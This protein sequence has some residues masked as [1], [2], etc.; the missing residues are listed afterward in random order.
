[1]SISLHKILSLLPSQ[2]K[3][4][5][6]GECLD[7]NISLYKQRGLQTQFLD[8]KEFLYFADNSISVEV[9]S[10]QMT[11]QENSL[12]NLD[13]LIQKIF[14]SGL[15]GGLLMGKVQGSP[16]YCKE[17]FLS[18]ESYSK[19]REGRLNYFY[20]ESEDNLSFFLARFPSK[21]KK[22]I[23]LSIN[24]ALIWGELI[25]E[26]LEDKR[27]ESELLLE[28]TLKTD[29]TSLFCHRE[30]LLSKDE[31]SK[32]L[33]ALKKREE[34][35]PLSYITEHRGFMGLDFF[36]S[37]SVLI[38]RPETE[39]LVEYLMENFPEKSF[40][41]LDICTG[42]GCIPLSI[43]HHMPLATFSGSDI[44]PEACEVAAKNAAQLGLQSR[45]HLFQGDL[46]APFPK[47]SHFDFITSN[48]PYISQESYSQLM[49]EVKFEPSLALIAGDG[50]D[51]YRRILDESHHYLAPGGFLLMEMGQGQRV[52]IEKCAPQHWTT[53]DVIVDYGGIDR[54]IVF[55]YSP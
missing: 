4:V 29:K 46:F 28:Y 55:R 45:F 25:L 14:Q 16:E 34:R 53:Q 23:P 8:F 10:I 5:F 13:I 2:G 33:D 12:E 51:F 40:H 21:S 18:L 1:M 9:F 15:P 11:E 43:L 37:P 44:S 19:K 47:P 31:E 26:K 24:Q 52:S 38:P 22:S 41:G 20:R 39:L 7:E 54:I 36:V 42:S 32:F 17:F 50:L 48:P 35:Y 49:P 3:M 30:R 6:L 27:L